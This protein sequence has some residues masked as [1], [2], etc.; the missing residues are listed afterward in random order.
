[1]IL[2]SNCLHRPAGGQASAAGGTGQR[3]GQA[4]GNIDV[5]EAPEAPRKADPG[6]GPF[7]YNRGA[8][9]GD[10]ATAARKAQCDIRE[11][12][13]QRP[14]GQAALMRNTQPTQRERYS[15]PA[16]LVHGS[17]DSPRAALQ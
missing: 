7:Q 14:G 11:R 1:M 8:G 16:A 4:A 12:D 9:G 6:T 13:R 3:E 10:S 15:A 2:P 5:T 17:R